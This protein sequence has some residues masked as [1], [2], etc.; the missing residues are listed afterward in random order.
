MQLNP[1]N[2][3][4]VDDNFDLLIVNRSEWNAI[5][6]NY[7]NIIL[8]KPAEYV[9]IGHTDSIFHECFNK[10]DCIDKVQE[11]QTLDWVYFGEIRWN[12]LVGGDGNIYEGRGWDRAGDLTSW[13]Y[14]NISLSIAFLGNFEYQ[15]PTKKQVQVAEKF[16]DYLLEMNKTEKDYKLIGRRQIQKWTADPGENVFEIIKKWDHWIDLRP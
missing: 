6:Y 10:Y 12:F 15:K 11:V 13:K 7:T 16:V 3:Q 9:I 5:D 2:F 14:D 4:F 8:A 1:K